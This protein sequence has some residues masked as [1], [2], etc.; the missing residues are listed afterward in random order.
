MSSQ[1][2]DT[3]EFLAREE[4]IRKLRAELGTLVGGVPKSVFA[5]LDM[6]TRIYV[7]CREGV[8][9]AKA[10]MPR[11]FQGAVTILI[12]TQRTQEA[13]ERREKAQRRAGYVG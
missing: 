2:L 4:E 12:V 8:E 7:R 11:T 5:K 3:E 6:E 1:G 9:R 10:R 13:I